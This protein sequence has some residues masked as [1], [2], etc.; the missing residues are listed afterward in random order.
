MHSM[1]YF[2]F[3]KAEDGIRDVAVTGV[4]T[5]ALPIS[6]REKDAACAR[7]KRIGTERCIPP[8]AALLPDKQ[9]SHSAR[10][11]LE[12]LRSPKADRAWTGALDKTSGQRKIGIITSLAMRATEQ[13][14]P[15]L[16]DRM[17]S[18]A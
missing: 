14:V 18:S 4:Q 3:F 13:A 15:A 5:C 11:A 16:G 8:L 1:V 2:L 9:L 7:L 17:D 6:P 10:Y 12:S